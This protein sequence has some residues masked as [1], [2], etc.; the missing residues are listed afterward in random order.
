MAE[1][2]LTKDSYYTDRYTKLPVKTSSLLSFVE[3]HSFAYFIL[4]IGRLEASNFFFNLDYLTTE[5]RY[6][7]DF[8]DSEMTTD[9]TEKKDLFPISYSYEILSLFDL[10]CDN[11]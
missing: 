2:L 5:Y 10:F 1:N 11:I 8:L 7:L 3:Q 6:A 9:M 4:H